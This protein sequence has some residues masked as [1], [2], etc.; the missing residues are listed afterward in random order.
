MFKVNNENT[1]TTSV[2]F[3]KQAVLLYLTIWVHGQFDLGYI[4]IALRQRR[5]RTTWLCAQA[6]F[7]LLSLIIH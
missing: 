7:E 3:N 1:K 5:V 2:N 6:G 4:H